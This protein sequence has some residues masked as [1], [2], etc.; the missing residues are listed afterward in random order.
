MYFREE[1]WTF[2]PWKQ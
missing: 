2:I 1:L